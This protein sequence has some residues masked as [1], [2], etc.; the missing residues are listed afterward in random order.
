[1]LDIHW[2]GKTNLHSLLKDIRFNL[3]GEVKDVDKSTFDLINFNDYGDRITA[4]ESIDL[5]NKIA[6]ALAKLKQ[7]QEYTKSSDFRFDNLSISSSIEDV[8]KKFK[9]KG[10]AFNEILKV[11]SGY[12]NWSV[13]SLWEGKALRW[14]ILSD[15][16]VEEI[17]NLEASNVPGFTHILT[18]FSK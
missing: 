3:Y 18:Y 8:L 2:T 6:D 14:N 7:M 1:M 17:E 12:C 9:T 13:E 11:F 15:E 10:G 5:S 16:D 4:K